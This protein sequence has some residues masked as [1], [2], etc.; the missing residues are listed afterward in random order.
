MIVILVHVVDSYAVSKLI[1]FEEKVPAIK[2]QPEEVVTYIT[3]TKE[4]LA[5]KMGE[6]RTAISSRIS[7]GRDAVTGHI[8][9]GK[10]AVYSK[11]SAG[12][13][14]FVNSR[15]GVVLSE[16]KEAI[17]NRIVEGKESLGST[18][19]SGRDA[20][21]TKIQD[22]KEH[23]ANT[24]A[25][26]LVG[27]GVDHTLSATENWV[28]YLL[29]EIEDEKE[30]LSQGGQELVGLP[31][32]RTPSDDSP[33]QADE[34]EE[35]PTADRAERVSTLSRKVKLRMYYHSV[36]KLQAVQQNC[37]GTLEQLKQTV[38]L[39]RMWFQCVLQFVVLHDQCMHLDHVILSSYLTGLVAS[40]DLWLTRYLMAWCSNLYLVTFN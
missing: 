33:A 10:D 27:S 19:A 30:L 12:K 25:G 16:G 34:K 26:A 11:I 13:E 40:C 29:P 17:A 18:I 21:Y 36:R 22:G 20:V 5:N 15:P 28:E 14:A 37:K 2:S 8:T 9:S 24:R 31:L 23:L 39:V 7:E 3:E 1:Q 4:A 32:T 35:A 6:G 38:D